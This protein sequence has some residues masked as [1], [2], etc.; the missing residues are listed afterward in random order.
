MT[1]KTT[2]A[3]KALS[4]D[5]NRADALIDLM[6]YYGV[7]S[8]RLISE[9]QGQAYLERRMQDERQQ[10]NSDTLSRRVSFLN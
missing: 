9:E 1:H 4:V 6:D 7:T 8:L 10:T 2:M 3:I 5:K